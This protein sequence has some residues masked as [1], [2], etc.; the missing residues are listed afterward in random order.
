MLSSAAGAAYG[1]AWDNQYLAYTGGSHMI[2]VD[3]NESQM[4]EAYVVSLDPF[5]VLLAIGCNV[6]QRGKNGAPAFPE[7]RTEIRVGS[8]APFLGGEAEFAAIFDGADRIE[9]GSFDYAGGGYSADLRP[10]V[11]ARFALGRTVRIEAANAGFSREFS[12][13]GAADAITNISCLGD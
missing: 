10:Q 5:R 7:I 13:K 2:R 1:G 12:L 3:R 6:T 11:L 9:L 8:G 4:T